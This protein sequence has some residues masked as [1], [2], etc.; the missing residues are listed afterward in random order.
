MKIAPTPGYLITTSGDSGLGIPEPRL[1]TELFF[2]EFPDENEKA[3][4]NASGRRMVKVKSTN[5]KI[6]TGFSNKCIFCSIWSYDQLIRQKFKQEKRIV[7][8]LRQTGEMSR[9]KPGK[10]AA[11]GS[12]RFSAEKVG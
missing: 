6:N 1:F 2:F 3:A 11:G 7:P 9:Q 5:T 8:T 10:K 12:G 4:R